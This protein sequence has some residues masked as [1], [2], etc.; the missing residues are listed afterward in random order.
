MTGT[1]PRLVF[2]CQH[3][4]GMGHFTRSIEI[5][6]GLTDF[7]VVFLNGGDRIPNFVLPAGVTFVDLPPI[8]S[9]AGFRRIQAAGGA[10]ELEQ[11]KAERTAR[12]LE[13]C[14]RMRPAVAVIELF[15]F[16]RR[17]FAFEL[18]PMLDRLRQFGAY[19]VCSLRDIVVGK[20]DQARFE[21]RTRRIVNRYFDLLLIH[22]DPRFQRLEETFQSVA[23]L[24]CDLQ[25]TGFVMQPAPPRVLPR[26]GAPLIV[27]SI[28][29]GRVGAE[30][31]Q[32]AI[33]ASALIELSHPHRMLAYSGPFIGEEEWNSAA[34]AAA[35]APSVTLDRFHPYFLDCLAGADLSISMAGYNT[36]MNIVATG[37][38]ALVHAFCGGGNLEQATR[39]QKL[40]QMGAVGVLAASDLAP[41]VLAD[42]IV[43]ML[44]APAP[45]AMA[46]DTNGVNRTAEL[47]A[48]RA[49]RVAA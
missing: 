46:L 27:V 40:E 23:E 20:E 25:Y 13:I 21:E 16:G 12:I 29:G 28:G 5:V 19:T 42:R 3:V 38:R 2:Y 1:R 15:P 49:S 48:A 37:V 34:E 18:V 7:D 39:A 47:L 9:D 36:C 43:R 4:L 45:G 30:L 6:K 44:N 32:S 17:K 24:T 31:L 26:G 11:V 10:L 8:K 22:S 35:S 33:R 41:A 14:E